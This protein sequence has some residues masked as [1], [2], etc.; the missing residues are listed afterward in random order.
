LFFTFPIH[1]R[2]LPFVI[3]CD[4]RCG[5]GPLFCSPRLSV[6][7]AWTDRHTYIYIHTSTQKQGSRP[8]HHNW[9]LLVHIYSTCV[10][11]MWPWFVWILNQTFENG[12][13][14]VVGFKLSPSRVACWCISATVRW[15]SKQHVPGPLSTATRH[16]CDHVMGG[17]VSRRLLWEQGEGGGA[18]V[19]NPCVK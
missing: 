9:R 2:D 4:I 7:S 12:R 16:A 1:Q 17:W 19:L 15:L 18:S 5:S 6:P 3:Y 13:V 11:V 14:N 10:C 8:T